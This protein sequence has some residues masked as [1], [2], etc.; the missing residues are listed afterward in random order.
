NL[1]ELIVK[2]SL[3]RLRPVLM[4]AAVASFGFLPMAISTSQGAE[5]QKPLAT[6]V[7]GGLITATLL[8][9]LVLPAIYYL[10]NAKRKFSVNG[11]KV[12]S[13]LIVLFCFS[14]SYTLKA[15]ETGLYPS[16]LK[17]YINY[18]LQNHPLI[19][20]AEIEIQK[21]LVEKKSAINMPPTELVW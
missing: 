5:V 10:V 20:N 17:E 3:V 11:N 9:L 19:K 1:R 18:G 15:Q 21:A 7:I 8:T 12:I 13:I 4:T 16:Q 6:V 2:G 14:T